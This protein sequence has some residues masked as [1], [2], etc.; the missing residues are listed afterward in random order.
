[1]NDLK[2]ILV[3]VDFSPSSATALRQAVRIAKWS[4]SGLRIVHVLETLMVVDLQEAMSVMQ[5]DVVNALN[6]DARASWRAFGATVPGAAELPFETEI[7]SA[8]AALTRRAGEPGVGLLVIGTHGP[9]VQKGVGPVATGCVRRAPS[10][11][12]LVQDPHDRPY[13]T[14]IACVDFSETSRRAVEQAAAVAARDSATLYV[15]HAYSTPWRKSKLKSPNIADLDVRF[16]DMTLARLQEFC[17]PLG[18]QMQ[19]L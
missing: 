8:V 7:N 4:R 1:M 6:A 9:E 13:T 11:V 18:A 2:T 19:Y 12:L 17:K 15:I 14:V 10:D 5:E 16:R 3:G